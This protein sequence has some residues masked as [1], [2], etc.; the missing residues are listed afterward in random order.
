[1]CRRCTDQMPWLY[2]SMSRIQFPCFQKIKVD[3]AVAS[4]EID[5]N[6][7]NDLVAIVVYYGLAMVVPD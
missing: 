2:Q 4:G 1:M 3:P 6:R 5:Y 7:V